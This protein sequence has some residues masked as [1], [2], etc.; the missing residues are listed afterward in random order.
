VDAVGSGFIGSRLDPSIHAAL[1]GV[2]SEC[3][4]TCHSGRLAL[5]IAIMRLDPAL[6]ISSLAIFT[7]AL[8]SGAEPELKPIFTG[9]DLSGWKVPDGNDAAGWDKAV[10]GV[11]KIQSDASKTGS[12]L[13]TEKS[14]HDF[15][16]SFDFKFGEGV[17]DTGIHLRNQD[18]IQIGISGSLKRD[19][20]GSPYAGG[21]YPVEAEGVAELLKPTE[22]NSMKI[23]A[24]GLHY[25]VWLNG[26]QVLD[27][28]ST[29]GILGGP[30]GIQL[31][32]A[33]TWGSNT[34]RSNSRNST[35]S[36]QAPSSGTVGSAMCTQV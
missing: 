22:W 32:G 23:E 16:I 6:L 25:L 31:H 1:G 10:D 17:I 24:R 8:V 11:L 21:K 35:K 4:L 28:S 36:L 34:V 15:V 30:I 18:Q 12:V 2:L 29:T 33:R 19:M 7:I 26:Q 27:Y 14:Y 3:T 9:T 20:T 13:W 5:K